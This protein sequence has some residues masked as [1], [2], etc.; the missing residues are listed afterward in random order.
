MLSIFSTPVLIRQLWQL[1]IVIFLHWCLIH[2][3]VLLKKYHFKLIEL[4][5]WKKALLN[6]LAKL[7]KKINYR[8]GPDAAE[9]SFLLLLA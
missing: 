8:T 9:G 7:V 5:E 1:K 2:A 6:L 4:S 3:V